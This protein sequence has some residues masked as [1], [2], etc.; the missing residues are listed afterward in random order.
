MRP[1]SFFL[2][3]AA[4][5]LLG[6]LSLPAISLAQHGGGHGGGGHGGGGW[7]GGGYYGGSRYNGFPGYYRGYGYGYRSYYPFLGLGWGYPFYGWGYGSSYPYY[8]SSYGS[9]YPSYDDYSYAPSTYAPTYVDQYYT[10]QPLTTTA[11]EAIVRV[12]VRPAAQVLFND[13]PTQQTGTDRVFT[14][15]PLDPSKQYT[16]NVTA[17]WTENGRPVT[18]SRTIAVIPGRTVDVDMTT[19]MPNAV[20]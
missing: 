13:T 5:A 19:P 4:L 3:F 6:F 14:T 12:H 18:A 8:G 9:Y 20:R 17:R 15:P 11:E 16:Y 7:H 1:R 10:S 2:G